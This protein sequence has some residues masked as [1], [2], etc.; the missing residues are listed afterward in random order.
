MS[1]CGFVVPRDGPCRGALP[2]NYILGKIEILDV[3]IS[4]PY[5]GTHFRYIFGLILA[6]AI[7][8][9][10]FYEYRYRS[11]ICSDIEVYLGELHEMHSKIVDIQ[12]YIVCISLKTKAWVYYAFL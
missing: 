7:Y 12:N 6:L 3:M 4:S 2:R 8:F 1:Q 11:I 10:K 9:F 5:S